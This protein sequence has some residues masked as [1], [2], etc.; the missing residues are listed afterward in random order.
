[1]QASVGR[2]HVTGFLCERQT[3]LKVIYVKLFVS[4]QSQIGITIDWCM[5]DCLIPACKRDSIIAWVRY[6]QWFT[7]LSNADCHLPYLKWIYYEIYYY[8]I[9][10]KT[11]EKKSNRHITSL[12]FC[13]VTKVLFYINCPM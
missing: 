8:K 4:L 5:F 2:D 11:I 13:Y 12:R 6:V 3:V 10:L 9:L 7:I 1:M